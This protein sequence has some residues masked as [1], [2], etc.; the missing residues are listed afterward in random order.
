MRLEAHRE[1]PRGEEYRYRRNGGNFRGGQNT[2]N[3]HTTNI[4]TLTNKRA[5][6]IIP[7]YMVLPRR[8]NP[9]NI[10]TIK[11]SVHRFFTHS[12][13]P[14]MANKQDTRQIGNEETKSSPPQT[15]SQQHK[16]KNKMA[17]ET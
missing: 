6:R 15:E 8:P 12:P 16:K 9:E 17:K 13:R 10:L 14:L 5:P 11:T 7:L 2:E 4:Q 1:Q 3:T